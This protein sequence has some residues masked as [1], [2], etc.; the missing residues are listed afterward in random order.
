MDNKVCIIGGG[1]AGLTAAYELL[2]AGVVPQLFEK[3]GQVGGLSKTVV[4]KGNRIDIGGHRFFSK[5]QRVVDFWQEILPL[6]TPAYPAAE[7]DLIMLLRRRLSRILFLGN[8]YDYPLSLNKRTFAN[9]G[10]ARTFKIGCSYL[11][12][13]LNPI[14]QEH[15]LADFLSNRFGRELYATFF[16]DYTQKVWGV[17]CEEIPRDWGVQR[18]K[19][20]SVTRAI[21]HALKQMVKVHNK[22]VETSL[23]EEFKYPKFGPGHLWEE[24]ARRITTGGGRISLH[25]KIVGFTTSSGCHIDS[26]VVEDETGKRGEIPTEQVISSMPIRDLIKL[27]PDVPPEVQQIAGQLPY[28]D[29]ITVGVLLDRTQVA[30]LQDNWVY[31]QEPDLI[32]GRIQIF[33]NWSPYMVAEQNTV[34]VG[35]EYF[36]QEG[37][38]FWSLDDDRLKELA[39]TELS[40]IKLVKDSSAFL[41]ATVIR[42][43]KAYPAYFGT[44]NQFQEIQTYLAKFDNLYLIGRNGQHRYNNMDHSMLTAMAAVDFLTG[45]TQAKEAIWQVNTEDS[46]HEEKK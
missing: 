36:C 7:N 32:M 6:E 5:S 4:Y 12:A 21:L 13:R 3:S 28:R 41:D 1:P 16:R 19:G 17:P 14:K 18:V 23:I 20:L 30:P 11:A 26:I 2:K 8:F 10:L 15:S 39:L 40:K 43:E 29:F 45:K 38:D 42:E 25:T 44:Y 33:N 22:H 46:Y 34:W 24:V 31:I 37:D 35:L 27:L 9:L